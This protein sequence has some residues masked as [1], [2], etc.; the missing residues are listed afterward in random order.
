MASSTHHWVIDALLVDIKSFSCAMTAELYRTQALAG[1][2]TVSA[3]LTGYH[4]ST[5]VTGKRSVN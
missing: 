3:S 5:S 1:V 2:G 4:E